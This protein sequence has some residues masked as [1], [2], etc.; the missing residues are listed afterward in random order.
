MDKKQ[1]GIWIFTILNRG[2]TILKKK[3]ICI[4]S[5]LRQYIVQFFCWF[6]SKTYGTVVTQKNRLIEMVLLISQ[7]CF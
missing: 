3:N 2:C 6:C 5:I 4:I 1:F 7:I